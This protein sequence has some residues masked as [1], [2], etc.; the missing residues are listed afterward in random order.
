M[1][2]QGIPLLNFEYD[3]QTRSP[4]SPM[5]SDSSFYDRPNARISVKKWY[6]YVPLCGMYNISSQRSQPQM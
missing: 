4:L 5:N 3:M 2:P 6:H 1:A